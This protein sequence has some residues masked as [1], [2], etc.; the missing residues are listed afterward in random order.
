[1]TSEFTG[2]DPQLEN[3]DELANTATPLLFSMADVD[4]PEEVDPRPLVRHDNQYNMGSCGG[5]GN[6]NCGENLWGLVTG[7]KSDERQFS[8]LYAYLEAQRLDGLLGQDKG[9]T[10]SSGLKVAKAGYLELKHL[11]YK[12]PYPNNART[13]ITDEM[14]TIANGLMGFRVRSHAWLESYEDIFKYLASR[15]G[16]VYVGTSW[17]NSF[18]AKS[19]VL[20]SVGFGRADG[21]HAYAFLGYSKRKDSKGRNYIWRLNSH[22]DSWA[23]VAPSVIDAL[24]RHQWSSIVGMSD[25][26][27][28]G[29][30]RVE[31]KQARP[32]E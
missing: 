5:F 12:T 31:W 1:M 28:P 26:L 10:I 8:Q 13:L 4:A 23:E 14:R 6:T 16:S 19:G 3:R 27:T 29:P 11:P 20:E 9:S 25:L 30:K 21:G 32:L 2:Y 24:C 15:A 18:Y 17:N 22:Q 7:Q